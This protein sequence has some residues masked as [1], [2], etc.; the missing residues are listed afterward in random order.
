FFA[1]CLDGRRGAALEVVADHD[2]AGATESL[3]GRG[4]LGQDLHAGT[5]LREHPLDALELALGPR[6]AIPDLSPALVGDEDLVD[7]AQADSL[8]RSCRHDAG[9]LVPSGGIS[10]AWPSSSSRALW[11]L[12]RRLR[13][14][15]SLLPSGAPRRLGS[16]GGRTPSDLAEALLER[17]LVQRADREVDEELDPGVEL[18]Q[19]SVEGASLLLV[20]A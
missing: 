20:R 2:A 3:L 18:S 17:H 1:A 12:P 4:D 14:V 8:L 5:I 15:P 13:D 19:S 11:S 10:Q 16:F 9:Q 7:D 6:K